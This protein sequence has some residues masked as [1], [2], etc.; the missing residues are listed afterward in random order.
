MGAVL[1]LWQMSLE[2]E[3]FLQDSDLPREDKTLLTHLMARASAL[4]RGAALYDNPDFR[5]VGS[6]VEVC[7]PVVHSFTNCLC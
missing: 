6:L 3:S 2:T 1:R 7:T 4:H 5:A